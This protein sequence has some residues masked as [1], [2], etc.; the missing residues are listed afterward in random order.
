M[1]VSAVKRLR[2]EGRGEPASGSRRH[3]TASTAS[4]RRRRCFS[5]SSTLRLARTDAVANGAARVVQL[6][7]EG[8][9]IMRGLR[10]IAAC[11][12]CDIC[13]R[14]VRL[15]TAAGP[16]RRG[17][18]SIARDARGFGGDQR[19]EHRSNG[20]GD[21]RQ[22]HGD[23]AQRRSLSRK[24][25]GEGL[26][27]PDGRPRQGDPEQIPDQS[28]DRG[29]PSSTAT[30]RSPTGRPWTSSIRSREASSARLAL[31]DHRRQRT[32]A[33]GRSSRC[34]SRRTSSTIRCST[35]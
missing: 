31:V 33:N 25:R 27:R 3:P 17:P 12:G 1:A 9:K 10:R 35:R 8:G 13:R 20:R 21:G 7:R 28:V 15:G 29:R 4:S 24:G 11:D 16:A 6:A 14:R 19:P 30:S 34:T 2:R 26:L 32:P 22:R 5:T 23:L 18:C